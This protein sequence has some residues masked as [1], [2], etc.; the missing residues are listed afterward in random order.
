MQPAWLYDGRSAVRHQVR[1]EREGA[2]LLVHF[3]DGSTTPAPAGC[4]V[5]V[6]SRD[7]AE[8][9]GRTDI[10]GWRLGIAG[11]PAELAGLLPAPQR[12]GRW[13]DRIGIVRASLVAVAASAA[14]LFVGSRAPVWLAPLVPQQWEERFGDAPIGMPGERVCSAPG[15][16]AALAKLA[17][18][19]APETAPRLDIR[20][21]DIGLVNAAALP[22]GN[23][24]IFRQLLT[25]A[26]SPDE[27]AGIIAHE[28]AH[29]EE[30]H[31]TQLM[32]RQLGLGMIV[33]AF[34]G[35]TGGSIESLMSAGFS[36][37]A[38]READA[39]AIEMLRRA[40]ISPLPTARFFERLAAR[41][42]RFG[43]VSAGLGYLSTHPLSAERRRKFEAS[44]VR[45]E[46]YRPVLSRE[47]WE[48]LVGAC[49]NDRGRR[50]A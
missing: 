17:R 45:G 28:I 32:I 35:P 14:V 12:Y 50:A 31:V 41:E 24:V 9:Y 7:S 6:E 26:E 48:A 38:E 21:I 1:V 22:G 25:E 15:T 39:R 27:V 5:H 36:R 40:G 44:A 30:R 37:G 23:I 47:E 11:V 18:T 49:R 13:I 43:K 16:Q 4:L 10:P 20:V 3:A 34:G 19:L 42:A 8:V 33:S 29:V 46:A 2:D